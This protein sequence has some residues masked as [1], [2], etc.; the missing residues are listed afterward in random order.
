[1]ARTHRSWLDYVGS[2]LVRRACK[3]LTNQAVPIRGLLTFA[4]SNPK[5]SIALDGVFAASTCGDSEGDHRGVFAQFSVEQRTALV[6][7][8]NR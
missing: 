3:T 7:W 4:I 6:M 1:M 5:R 8:G 2:W